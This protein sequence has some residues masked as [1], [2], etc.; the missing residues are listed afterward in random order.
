M[1]IGMCPTTDVWADM[2]LHVATKRIMHSNKPAYF[3]LHLT[4]PK[5]GIL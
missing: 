5:Y 3:L 4:T 2:P 1:Y